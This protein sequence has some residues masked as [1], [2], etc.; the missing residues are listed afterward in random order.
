[1]TCDAV[2]LGWDAQRQAHQLLQSQRHHQQLYESLL[3]A[4]TAVSQR[5]MLV[6][7]Q[8]ALTAG[9]TASLPDDRR[10]KKTPGIWSPAA[11]IESH[12]NNNNNNNITSNGCSDNDGAEKWKVDC[13]RANM[14]CEQ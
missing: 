11:D 10:V 1:M 8:A 3:A 4:A 9:I 6:Q 7:R 5:T 14:R 13:D 12:N 2:A